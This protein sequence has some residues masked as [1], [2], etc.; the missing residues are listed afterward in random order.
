[1]IINYDRG[2]N[3]YIAALVGSIAAFVCALTPLFGIPF[4]IV[5]GITA[6][7]FAILGYYFY[8]KYYCYTEV[9]AVDNSF[10][11][12]VPTTCPFS[13]GAVSLP[14]SFNSF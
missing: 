9:M 7:V 10:K 1:M 3:M 5:F 13:T 11:V 14:S 6:I 4:V 2:N 12:T 8:N